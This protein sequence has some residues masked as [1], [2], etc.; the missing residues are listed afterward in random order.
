MKSSQKYYLILPVVILL[1]LVVGFILG[2]YFSNNSISRKFFLNSGNKIDVILD[3]INDQYVDSVNM[4]DM[5]EAAIP[6]FLKELDPHSTY[7]P[8]QDLETVNEEMDG[9]F[10]G[11]GV[12]FNRQN[13]TIIVVNVIP[14]GP[15]EKVG[16]QPGD[17]IVTINDSIFAGV[18]ASDEKIVKNLKGPKGSKVRV[19]VKRANENKI[20]EYEITRGDVPLNT[21]DVAYEVSNGIG[22]IKINKFGKKTHAEFLTA[23]GELMQAGCNAFIID[24]RQ[25]LG[26]AFDAAINIS[27]E[28]LPAG[29]L[30]TYAE[31]KA[32]PRTEAYANGTGVCQTQPVIILTDEM[33]ASASEIVAGAIQDNDR[34]LIIG[35][36]TFG[37]GLVQTQLDLSDGSAIRLTTARY[38]TPSGRCIQK[39]YELGKGTEYELD[40]INRFNHGEFDSKDSINLA[41]YKQ[42]KTVMG[43]PVYDGGG[44]MPDIFIP[45][46]TAGMTSYYSLLLQNAVIQGYAFKY[47]DQ[48]RE[49]LNK[50]TNYKKLW[51]YLKTQPLLDGVVQYA[52]TKGIRPRP[53]LINISSGLITNLTQAYIVRNFFD[54]DGFYPI[55]FHKDPVIMKAIDVINKGEAFPTLQEDTKE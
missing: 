9:H 12:Q 32:F 15:S 39:N 17:R 33:S 40:L 11:I 13:D 50:F 8:S 2:N 27:N 21:V 43:R 54:D 14:G 49:K 44:V 22:F 42:F 26:G 46:D 55:Y 45:R 28:F 25:N 37:K 35:R 4:K 52:E 20:Q 51:D 1:T 24:L 5:V 53:V 18:G 6:N 31:G 36:R 41:G 19:G 38:Y 47:S 23:V 48:Y 10:S 16:I 7:I 34:G 3:I 30:I 29:R